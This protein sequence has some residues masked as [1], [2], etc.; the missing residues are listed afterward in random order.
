MIFLIPVI[1]AVIGVITLFVLGIVA[2]SSASAENTQD[3]QCRDIHVLVERPSGSLACMTEKTAERAADR[4]GWKIIAEKTIPD[5]ENSMFHDEI[6]IHDDVKINTT[7]ES[8]DM[9][10]SYDDDATLKEP[11]KEHANQQDMNDPCYDAT[12]NVEYPY[13][14]VEPINHSITSGDFVKLC[15]QSSYKGF[16]IYLDAD[17]EWLPP[18][19]TRDEIIHP[20]NY[21]RTYAA[22]SITLEVPRDIV[23]QKHYD[24]DYLDC[25][26]AY[27]QDGK[28]DY[29]RYWNYKAEHI[30]QTDKTRTLKFTYEMPVSEIS[31]FGSFAIFDDYYLFKD[32][33][34][35]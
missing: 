21:P 8:T 29:P 11:L 6:S 16:K 34:F 12:E 10:Q 28:Y 1:W 14:L 32:L 18:E 33:T 5:S 13:V 7:K 3:K 25:N 15:A 30:A 19:L 17:D 2:A 9:A 4:F 24:P 26:D 31:Y 22:G 35:A 23:D 27:Y 20:Q